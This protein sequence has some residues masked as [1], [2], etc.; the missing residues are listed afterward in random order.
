M[1]MFHLNQRIALADSPA[2]SRPSTRSSKPH[3][4]FLATSSFSS[5]QNF[6]SACFASIHA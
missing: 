4:P 1:T 3:A 2:A 5:C 6:T